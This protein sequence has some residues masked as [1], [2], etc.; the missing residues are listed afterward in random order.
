MACI[1]LYAKNDR[2]NWDAVKG[3]F[4]E[5]DFES[6]RKSINLIFALSTIAGLALGISDVADPAMLIAIAG[7]ASL[8]LGVDHA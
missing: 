1:E 6:C 7:G 2:L 4:D 5:K 8:V 3:L